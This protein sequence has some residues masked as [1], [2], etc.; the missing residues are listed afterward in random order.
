MK[1]K[2][3]NRERAGVEVAGQNDHLGTL[4]VKHTS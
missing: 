1:L 3:E 4:V 2:D